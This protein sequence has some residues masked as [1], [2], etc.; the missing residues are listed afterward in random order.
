[1]EP[2]ALVVDALVAPAGPQQIDGVVHGLAP[3]VVGLSERRVLGFLPAHAD[4][5]P[6]PATRERVERADLLGHQHR[7]ALRE[8]EDFGRHGDA[9]GDGGDETEGDQRLQDRHLGRVDGRRPGRGLVAHHDVIEDGDV[10]VAGLLDPPGEG[11]DALRTF[12]TD[13]TRELDRQL[14]ARNPVAHRRRGR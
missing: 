13:D 14:H 1:M 7:L 9:V 5:E 11:P 4:T 3:T 2:D 10:V 8:D 12:T 6:H